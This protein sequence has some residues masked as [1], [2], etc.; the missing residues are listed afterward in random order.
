M[1]RSEGAASGVSRS[2]ALHAGVAEVIEAHARRARPLECCGLLLGTASAIVDAIPTRNMSERPAMGYV[3]DPAEHFATIRLAR[4]SDLEV[5]G[6]YH[7]HVAT[8]ARP[9]ET[10]RA[11]A[12]SDFLFLIVSLAESATELTAW[13]LVTGN[14][15]PVSLVRTA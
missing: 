9:S 7:S 13:E 2:V 14:F 8:A 4:L 3:I 12:F 6:A 15:V 5:V 10:D 11:E 1:S